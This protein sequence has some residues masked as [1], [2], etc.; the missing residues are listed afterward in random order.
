MQRTD[1]GRRESETTRH[2]APLGHAAGVSSPSAALPTP[3]DREL[4][5]DFIIECCEH[6]QHMD[7]ALLALETD[8]ADREA[9]DI[10]FLSVSRLLPTWRITQN[11]S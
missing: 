9:I 11:H 6:V 10:A 5:E 2:A 3:I 7:V 8:P 4:L 1:T